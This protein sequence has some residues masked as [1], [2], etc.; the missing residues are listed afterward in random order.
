[1]S[2]AISESTI[3]CLKILKLREMYISFFITYSKKKKRKEERIKQTHVKNF[4]PYNYNYT[5]PL[6]LDATENR[7]ISGYAPGKVKN[8][9]CHM[10][11]KATI[12]K[13]RFKVII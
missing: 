10:F 7:Y 11:V 6:I 13:T 9:I 8:K 12:I 4:Y 2:N 3:W 5:N 1:M